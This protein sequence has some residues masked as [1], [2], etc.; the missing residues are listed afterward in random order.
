VKDFAILLDSLAFQPSRNGKLT[1]LT[2]YFARTPDPD[3][4]Y[5]LAALASDLELA[6]AKPKLIRDLVAERVD[7][8][9]FR[10]SYDF[11]GD[12][13]E[14]AALV[15]PDGKT[16]SGPTATP[17]LKTIVEDLNRMGRSKTPGQIAHWLDNMDPTT[18]W[19][20]LK[21]IT[22]KDRVGRTRYGRGQRGGRGLARRR[23]PLYGNLCVAGRTGADTG[24]LANSD[25]SS[26]DAGNPHR[27]NRSAGA[28][29]RRLSGG[30]EVGRHPRADRGPER[31]RRG[32]AE[33]A[34]FA[35]R[36]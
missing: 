11:V 31:R 27:G 23:A 18:R 19:G 12:L 29:P 1:L 13:A 10:L 6:T 33:T 26:A 3:R 36:R 25:I 5:A 21:L 28:R 22:R 8:E 24:H 35:H 16:E 2:D 32:V 15:W 9:L 20:L 14:T 30:M 34:L 4:G 7:P 17:G